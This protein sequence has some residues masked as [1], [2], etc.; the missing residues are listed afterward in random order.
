M[1]EWINQSINWFWHKEQDT[2]YS[3]SLLP[4]PNNE[5]NTKKSRQ[6]EVNKKN[7]TSHPNSKC[8]R[9]GKCFDVID[10]SVPPRGLIFFFFFA[11]KNFNY[12]I[13]FLGNLHW[14]VIIIITW[15]YLKKKKKKNL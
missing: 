8:Q 4:V 9:P 5:W 13:T 12:I 10:V 11:P 7:E 14:Y 3:L 15:L 1:N 6:D 2:E